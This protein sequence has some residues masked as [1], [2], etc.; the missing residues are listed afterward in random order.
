VIPSTPALP[1]LPFTCRSF[2]DQ[3]TK[4]G[5]YAVANILRQQNPLQLTAAPLAAGICAAHQRYSG[6][7]HPIPD[8]VRAGLAPY[9]SADI[10]ARAKYTVGAV[11]IT[12]PNFIN[13]GSKLLGND[14]AVVVDDIIVFSS[15]PPSFAADSWWWGHEMTHVRQYSQWGVDE[16]AWRYVRTF[17]NEVES[18][19]NAQGDIVAG[20]GSGPQ[21]ANAP[22]VGAFGSLNASA[23]GSV[24]SSVPVQVSEYFVAQ[25]FFQ[26]QPYLA[27]YLITNTNR[28]IVVDPMSGRW[29]QVGW[30][31]PPRRP[32]VAWSFDT[33]NWA[34][35]VMH[36][37]AITTPTP[38]YGQLQQIGYAVRLF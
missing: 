6:S 2:N 17:G 35:A 32:G 34:Y 5:G 18:E 23:A 14:H 37:G 20:A 3:L 27:H 12:L 29:Q 33:P 1:L 25:C 10:L 21:L 13:N 38:P 9:F 30:A 15:N 26:Y 31:T 24:R 7:A 28:I 19:A 22:S 4:S 36:D 8:D 11:E 16:F